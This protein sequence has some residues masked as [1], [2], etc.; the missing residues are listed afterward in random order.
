MINCSSVFLMGITLILIYLVTTSRKNAIC[1]LLS[2]ISGIAASWIFYAVLKAAGVYELALRF[3]ALFARFPSLPEEADAIVSFVYGYWMCI[4]FVLGFS[5]CMV[6][7]VRI[8]KLENYFSKKGRQYYV[9][10][11]IVI[12]FNMLLSIYALLFAI[13]DW[14]IIYNLP[15]SFFQFLFE[16]AQEGIFRL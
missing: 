3:G 5:L 1:V 2:L 13:G 14:N 8:L 12:F 7:S 4:V 9:G 11:S 6:L 15:G 10:K 16:L